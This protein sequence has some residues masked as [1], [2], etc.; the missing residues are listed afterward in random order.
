MVEPLAI[1][2][3]LGTA[4]LANH[5]FVSRILQVDSELDN[6]LISGE[7]NVVID[8]FPAERKG[9]GLLFE[10]RDRPELISILI[11]S[12]TFPISRSLQT[13]RRIHA[14]CW[15]S[16]ISPRKERRLTVAF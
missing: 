8:G 11:R 2:L 6:L 3:I 15:P 12:R 1:H 7:R 14:R 5:E 4:A 13:K 16:G 9:L 10:R